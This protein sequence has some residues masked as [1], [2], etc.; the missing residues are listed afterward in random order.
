MHTSHNSSTDTSSTPCA[1]EQRIHNFLAEQRIGV[2]STVTPDNNPHGTVVYYAI[3]DDC[4]IHIL[5]KKGT[6]KYDNLV[7]NNHVMLTVFEPRKQITA[8]VTGVA[9]ER[10]GRAD[11]SRIAGAIFGASSRT[12]DS[13]LPPI[14]KLQAGAFTT[15]RIRPVQ[16]RM[17]IYARPDPGSY[18][19]I[20]ESVE[21]FDFKRDS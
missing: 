7:H 16:I 10:E 2:L 6:R 1:R 18:E 15:F 19:S 21:S 9:V 3:D 17:A 13:G 4:T 12:S 20:F 11:I 5:T 14:V 8:Q